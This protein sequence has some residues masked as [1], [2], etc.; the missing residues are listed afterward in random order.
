MNFV[1]LEHQ[2]LLNPLTDLAKFERMLKLILTLS[3]GVRHT[4]PELAIRFEVSERSIH[5]YI[6]TFRD[7]GF[8][9]ENRD[10][11]YWL[12]KVEPPFNKL[13]DLLF[14]TEEEAYILTK[15]IHT[16]DENNVLKQNLV[17]K[18]YALYKFGKVADTI[19]RREQSE[20]IHRLATAIEQKK[21]VVLRKYH[22]SHGKLIRDR[23]V[24]PFAFTT[25]F[26]S[27]WAFDP[28][29]RTNKLFKTARIQEV[30]ITGNGFT[31]AEQHQELPVDVFRL[32]SDSKINIRLR[33]SLR[34]YNLL[35]E[36]YPLAG[37]FITTETVNTWK[38]DGWVCSFEGVGRFILGLCDEVE[39]LAPTELQN[40]ISEKVKNLITKLN[41]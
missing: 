12:D 19:I 21:Q 25:N 40:F 13:S 9:I 11:Y 15:A 31:F 6:R 5:R 7:A 34:A 37:Q 2:N 22:S 32:S 27:V 10:G 8:G 33:L 35:I 26:I 24:E 28:E 3:S 4:I 30:L 16:I 1:L 36:E 29:S 14:F 23:L 39:I 20:N 41:E 17:D 38:F 18:L